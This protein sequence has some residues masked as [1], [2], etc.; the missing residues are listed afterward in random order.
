[1][2]ERLAPE[3][4]GRAGSPGAGQLHAGIRAMAPILLAYAPFALVVGASVAASTEPWAAWAGTWLVYG[5]A[6]HLALLDVLAH[7]G[8]WMAA[9]AVG[10]LVN[11]RLTAYAAA[12]APAWRSEPMWRRIAAAVMLT[13]APW[14]LARDRA[15]NAPSYYFGAAITLFV[16]WP[17]MVTA[18]ALIGSHISAT[19]VTDLVTP[20]TLGA[21]VVPQLRQR[22]VAAAMAAGGVTAAVTWQADTG[23][24]L[25][26]AGSVGAACGVLAERAR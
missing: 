7:G 22:P 10:L 4:L 11:A 17:A 14:A 21:V 25:L 23:T 19:P 8:G 20:L 3:A 26:L 5:G 12:M 15:R 2:T 13:D 24:A 6:A 9:A 16:A 1:M 18:G